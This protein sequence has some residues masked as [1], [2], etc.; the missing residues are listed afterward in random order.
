VRRRFA[1]RVDG[2]LVGGCELRLVGETRAEASYWTFPQFRRRGYATR[3]LRL[4]AAWASG[5]GVDRV[6]LHGEPD[7]VA[8]RRVAERSGFAQTARKTANGLLVYERSVGGAN[9]SSR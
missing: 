9:S 3:A 7:N 1:T 4:L 6:E 2:E 5:L 8:S